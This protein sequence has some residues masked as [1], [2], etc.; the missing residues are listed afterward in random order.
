MVD[1]FTFAFSLTTNY[2]THVHISLDQQTHRGSPSVSKT[3]DTFLGDASRTKSIRKQLKKLDL[4]ESKLKLEEQTKMET[5]TD[6][7]NKTV[8]LSDSITKTGQSLG[9]FCM[10]MMDAE[11]RKSEETS[12]SIKRSNKGNTKTSKDTKDRDGDDNNNNNTNNT[13]DDSNSDIDDTDDT[14]E[15]HQKM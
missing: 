14:D 2:P 15:H 8:L 7:D 5:E 1:R 9:A 4:A 11:H 13:N 3:Q 6:T 10:V 12:M